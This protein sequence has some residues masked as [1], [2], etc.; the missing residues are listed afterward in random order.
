MNKSLNLSKKRFAV[1]GLGI[2]GKSVVNYFRK[3]G[4]RN[5]IM[6]D[7]DK[8]IRKD[9][10]LEGKKRNNFYKLLDS[11]DYII[12]SPGISPKK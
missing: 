6:W 11:V 8:S 12:I 3:V 5:Y 2:T 10:K 4:F 9:W 7:D 1:Y